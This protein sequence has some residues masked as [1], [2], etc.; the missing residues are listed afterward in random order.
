MWTTTNKCHRMISSTFFEITALSAI[1]SGGF[2][3]IGSSTD[4]RSFECETVLRPSGSKN[5][6]LKVLS[7]LSTSMN[8]A[9]AASALT[10]E[11]TIRVADSDCPINRAP[12][13]HRRNQIFQSS[14]ADRKLSSEF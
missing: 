14:E 13:V 3:H 2:A 7:A 5:L 4:R 8:T 10:G 6:L 12:E 11:A 9:N 1:P